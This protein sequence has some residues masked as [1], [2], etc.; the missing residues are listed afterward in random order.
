V[1]RDPIV[2]VGVTVVAISAATTSFTSL[3]DLA[4]AAGWPTGLTYLLPATVDVYGVVAT[5]IATSPDAGARVKKHASFHAGVALALS[6]TGN[7]ISHSLD[8]KAFV[9]GSAVWLLVVAVSLVPPVALGALMHLLALRRHGVDEPAVV[10]ETKPSGVRNANRAIGRAT[11][12]LPDRTTTPRTEPVTK[13]LRVG[14]VA[15]TE[16]DRATQPSHATEPLTR[17]AGVGTVAT[18]PADRATPEPD[19]SDLVSA[20]KKAGGRP[21]REARK[22]AVEIYQE[23]HR[24]NIL[25]NDRSLMKLVNDEFGG[26]VIGRTACATVI[27]KQREAMRGERTG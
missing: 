10:A 7:A 26:E 20:E 19:S 11:K 9:L 27:R 2:V 17:P 21:P 6:M 24:R 8:A 1:K 25:L 3:S 5:R 15:A 14:P 22:R 4:H 16:P 18:E 12:P 23:H 13:P